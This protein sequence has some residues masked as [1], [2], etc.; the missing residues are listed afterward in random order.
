[1]KHGN[2]HWMVRKLNGNSLK[3]GWELRV[4][5]SWMS[6]RNAYIERATCRRRLLLTCHYFFW[7]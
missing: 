5:E 6:I 2:C 3:N 4:N 1:M 7:A